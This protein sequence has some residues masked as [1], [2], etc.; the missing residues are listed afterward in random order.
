M[1]VTTEATALSALLEDAPGMVG[2]VLGTR[3][4][5]LRAVIGGARDGEACAATAAVLTTGLAAIGSQLGLGELGVATV[6]SPSAA[7]LFARQGAAVLA[8]ELDPKRPLG[9]FEGKLLKASWAP[10]EE[11]LEGPA[12]NRV[13]TVP[14]KER[15]SG[16][17]RP[18]PNTPPPPPPARSQ[19]PTPRQP[20][21]STATGV[22]RATPS[23]GTP[24]TPPPITG[25]R[26]TGSLGNGQ[27]FAGDL[28]EFS[29]PDLLEFLRNSHRT[30][31]LV[32]STV[33]GTGT[34]QLSRGMIVSA[35]SPH[36]LDLREHF[37]ADPGFSPEQRRLL[38]ALP[39]ECFGDTMI[40]DE[41]VSRNLVQR[42]EVER[43]RVARIY[44]A[45]REMM[46]WTTGRFSFDPTVPIVTNAPLALSAHSILMQIFQ[47]QDEQGR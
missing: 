44:S 15:V 7:R 22:R 43:L 41:L 17:T 6:K 18:P 10:S 31:L 26:P 23:A 42:D 25:A 24:T 16:S 12:V 4:G 27:V 45:F 46:G 20:R 33:V 11:A 21:T 9:A 19:K 32:C 13:P 36:A 38:A 30:G 5:E 2:A 29:L 37:L 40:A 28:E 35:D 34:V 8:I 1:D 47:E 39:T 3:D 14:L